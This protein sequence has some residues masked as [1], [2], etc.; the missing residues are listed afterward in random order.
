MFTNREQ[1]EGA[2]GDK[3]QKWKEP[4]LEEQQVPKAKVAEV[5]SPVC[6]IHC[7][8]GRTAH[9][10]NH[11]LGLRPGSADLTVESETV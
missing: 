8:P 2:V 1:Q 4:L 9:L 6:S 5:A 11:C 3:A 7:E 10:L